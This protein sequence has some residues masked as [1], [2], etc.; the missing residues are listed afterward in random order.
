MDARVLLPFK[1]DERLPG[2]SPFRLVGGGMSGGHSGID[3]IEGRANAIKLLFRCI[4]GISKQTDV[5]IS[6]VTGGTA[7]NA[8]PRD[9][10]AMLLLPSEDT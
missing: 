5:R 7:R 9:A 1:S 3:I 10:E 4:H 6:T 8:I 2:H